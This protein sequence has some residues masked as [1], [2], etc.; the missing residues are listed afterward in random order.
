MLLGNNYKA[1][2]ICLLQ[3]GKEKN[4]I[5]SFHGHTYWSLCFVYAEQG[6]SFS[7]HTP[8]ENLTWLMAARGCMWAKKKRASGGPVNTPPDYWITALSR[9]GTK[10]GHCMWDFSNFNSESGSRWVLMFSFTIHNNLLH[11][12]FLLIISLIQALNWWISHYCGWLAT[13]QVL[14]TE[15]AVRSGEL[16]GSC[17]SNCSIWRGFCHQMISGS[18]YPSPFRLTQRV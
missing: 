18:F 2:A 4:T 6:K 11:C 10:E 16:Q 7:P 17:S 15:A 8:L 13:V 1:D 14:L 9:L 5:C 3:A 12:V